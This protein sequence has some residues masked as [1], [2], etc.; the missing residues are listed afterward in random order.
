M[1][2]NKVIELIRKKFDEKG[3]PAKIPLIKGNRFFNAT[4]KDEGIYVNNLNTQPFLPWDVFVE[5]I[6]LITIKGGKAF[7]GN[8]M[9][10]KLGK[11][12]LPLDSIEGHI[13]CSIYGKKVNDSVFRRISPIAGIL[14]WASLCRN[15]PGYLILNHVV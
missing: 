12:K 8:A 9:N 6:K 14:V 3:N 1:D 10:S 11:D 5:A 7:K 13:A 2:E 15:E 4:M